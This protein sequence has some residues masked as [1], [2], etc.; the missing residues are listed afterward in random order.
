MSREARTTLRLALKNFVSEQAMGV[1]A[2]LTDE[3]DERLRGLAIDVTLM[4]SKSRPD[5]EKEAFDVLP[6]WLVDGVLDAPG[7][8]TRAEHRVLRTM[9]LSAPPG[10]RA[11]RWREA[12]GLCRRLRPRP[13]GSRSLW[14]DIRAVADNPAWVE[15]LI[16]V[17]EEGDDL[18]L[19]Y[20]AVLVFDGGPRA[21][22]GLRRN[23]RADG[24]EIED[25]LAK[26]AADSPARALL[27]ELAALRAEAFARSPGGVLLLSLG[28]DADHIHVV[29]PLK[30]DARDA[31]LV[32]HVEAHRHHG[33]DTFDVRCSEG[34]AET[35]FSEDGIHRDELGLGSCDI[36]EL[37]RWIAD[38]AQRLNLEWTPN[39][40]MI[41]PPGRVRTAVRRWLALP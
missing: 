28:V 19:P 2:E 40:P 8:P 9:A 15:V 33:T 5:W 30:C 26:A 11:A 22:A 13:K 35:V 7:W 16:R 17:A 10:A 1:I 27:D 4:A 24:C 3:A 12:R 38:A 37:P 36:L 18:P 6:E 31:S 23:L 41:N 32:V 21:I 34:A 20:A 25:A 29:V 39:D 14:K